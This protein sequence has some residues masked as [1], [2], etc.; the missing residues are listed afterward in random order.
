MNEK[1]VERTDGPVVVA[2][3][4]T[5]DGTRAL[6]YGVE[7]AL[8]SGRRLR[9]V[10]VV[11]ETVPMAPMLPLFSS[12]TLHSLAHQVLRAATRRARDLGADDVE[13]VAAEGARV[14]AILQHSGDAAMI[15]VG[16]RSSGVRRMLTG[17]TSTGVAH[18]AA[19]P[20]IAVPPAWSPDD[21][22]TGVVA[23][24]DGSDYSS[25]VIAAAFSA[26]SER[27]AAL[28]VLHAWRPVGEYDAII[29]ERTMVDGWQEEVRGELAELCAPFEAQYPKVPLTLRIEYAATV[30]AL[31]DAS[32]H[33][34]LL[35]LGRRGRGAAFSLPL[36]SVARAMIGG[37]HCPVELVPVSKVAETGRR[38]RR[39]AVASTFAPTY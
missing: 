28:T 25:T 22:T 13:T 1:L 38:P 11:H 2:V 16:P 36:G 5:D 34:D 6:T 17:S 4:G 19:C 18:R 14:P 7:Q 20:V 29:V 23:A 8:R 10:H 35:V 3:D 15:V 31:L 39:E 12:E 32:T 9:L 26:A 21:R 33:A 27:H 24:V 30:P 37:A